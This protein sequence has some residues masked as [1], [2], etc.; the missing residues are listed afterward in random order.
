MLCA[1]YS[2]RYFLAFGTGKNMDR[3]YNGP[4]CARMFLFKF[5]VHYESSLAIR[6]VLLHWIS[7]WMRIIS[8]V[9]RTNTQRTFI[10]SNGLETAAHTEPVSRLQCF[11]V[12]ETLNNIPSRCLFCPL[13]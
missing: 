10:Q 12:C 1:A 4:V 9:L 2:K 8:H 11:Q 7:E 13:P 5:I 6:F 3:N